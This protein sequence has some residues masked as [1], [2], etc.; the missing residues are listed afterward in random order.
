MD[1]P[2][3]SPFSAPSLLPRRI[4]CADDHEQ[5]ALLTQLVLQRAGHSVE[6][7]G[8]GE[9]AW[10]RIITAPDRFDLLVTDH[11]MPR[12]T[13]LQLVQKLRQSGH[14][15]QIIVQSSFLSPQDEQAFT[16]L[17]VVAILRKPGSLRQLARSVSGLPRPDDHDQSR[18]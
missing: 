15:L 14:G 8:D 5:M 17:G 4:L 18:G 6:C 1:E 13:G 11:Q 3:R 9:Q 12:L 7:V 10:E 16:A 2:P